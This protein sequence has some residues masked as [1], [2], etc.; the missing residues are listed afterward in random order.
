[1]SQSAARAG[2]YPEGMR[3]LLVVAVAAACVMGVH[4]STA[5]DTGRGTTLRITYWETSSSAVRDA[6]WTLRC[7]PPR[8]TLPRRA[9][10]CRKL[11]KGGPKLFAPV[12]P[13]TVCTEIYGG[14]QKALVRGFVAGKRVRTTFTRV[15]GC[16]I[17]RW[18]RLSPWLLPRGGVTR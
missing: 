17:A 3:V 5:A 8:G 12:P 14:P 15:N 9:V 16:E 10:A 11:A 13:K 7:N 4:A 6:T 2:Q 1:V 18:N